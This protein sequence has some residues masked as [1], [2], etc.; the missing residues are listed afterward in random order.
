MEWCMKLVNGVPVILCIALDIEYY[1]ATG[2]HPMSQVNKVEWLDDKTI[3]SAGHD[4][5]VKIWIFTP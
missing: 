5:H 4:G 2:A 1:V 3:V